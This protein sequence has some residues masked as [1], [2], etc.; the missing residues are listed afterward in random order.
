MR[1]PG[2]DASQHG[3]DMMS[4]MQDWLVRTAWMGNTDVRRPGGGC[5]ACSLPVTEAREKISSG[6]S[7]W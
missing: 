5:G 1:Q 7:V 2:G 3:W 6:K 4:K